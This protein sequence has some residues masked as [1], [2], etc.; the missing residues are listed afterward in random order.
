MRYC[1]LTAFIRSVAP[2]AG[3]VNCAAVKVTL[4]LVLLVVFSATTS[5]PI[6]TVVP[7]FNKLIPDPISFLIDPD[8]ALAVL[9]TN[10]E[11]KV[12]VLCKSAVPDPEAVTSAAKLCPCIEVG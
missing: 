6:W 11:S 2:A 12:P 3:A 4:T 10:G 8:V 9:A 7:L 1:N 5:A